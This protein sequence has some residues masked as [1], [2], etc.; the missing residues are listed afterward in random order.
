M[1]AWDGRLVSA[2]PAVGI[3]L[4]AT[5]FANAARAE[6]KTNI[7]YSNVGGQALLLDAN[8]PDGAGPFPVV[9]AVHGGGWC[10]GDK[11][12]KGDFAPVLK[13]LTANHFTW[14]SIDYRLGP[15]NHWPACFDD[16]QAAIR[17]VKAHSSE[18]KG[19][20]NRI[21]LLGYSAGGHL[22]C[23]AATVAEADT[24]VQAVVGLAPPT[25]LVAD[26]ERHGGVGRWPAMRNLLG[27][28]SM[29]DE[30]VKLL[31]Q[32][33]PINHVKPGLPPFLLMQGDSD[34]TVLPPSTREFAAKLQQ[35]GVPC[36][37]YFLKGPG[38][39]IAD[40]EK[41]DPAYQQKLVDWLNQ[42][43]VAGSLKR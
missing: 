13:A 18:Y 14:F 1:P 35:N 30:T 23:L 3:F 2:L 15:T 32:M 21:A 34:E 6:L 9:I 4:A 7:E 41:F 28:G 25:D 19:D 22:V 29:N 11:S 43:L 39:P 8:V 27:S 5:L 12:G 26:A 37:L 10:I 33:S 24:S 17:W 38:H 42:T 16:V 20:P 31:R 40:W 36:E